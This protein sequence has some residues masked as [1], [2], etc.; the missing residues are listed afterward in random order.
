[1]LKGFTKQGIGKDMK[2]LSKY[3]YEF[4]ENEARLLRLIAATYYD[5]DK[6]TDVNLLRLFCEIITNVEYENRVSLNDMDNSITA[7]L[8]K[9][10]L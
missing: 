5:T 3:T 6:R 2:R 9:D 10:N 4:D 1:M 8:Q 7:G